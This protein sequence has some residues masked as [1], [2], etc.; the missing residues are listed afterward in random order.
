MAEITNYDEMI[1]KADELGQQ[2]S[3]GQIDDITDTL[4]N[5]RK[6]NTSVQELREA[7][8]EAEEFNGEGEE[9][10]GIAVID[11]SSGKI[12]DILDIESTSFA[13][14]TLDDI[15]ADDRI[16]AE[17]VK[18]ENAIVREES[19]RNVTKDLF[20]MNT[21]GDNSPLTVM[22]IHMITNAVDRYKKGEKFP[23][24]NAMPQI[25]KDQ[26]NAAMS[27]GE[28][29]LNM[30]SFIKQGRNYAAEEFLEYIL[31]ESIVDTEIV[32]LQH[33]MNQVMKES[34]DE[35]NKTMTTMNTTQKKYYEETLLEQAAK[36]KEHGEIEKAELLKRCSKNYIQA[37]TYENLLAMY[38]KGK[39]K[40]KPIQIDKFNRTCMEFNLKY[41]DSKT[42]ITDIS[43]VIPV[44]DRYADKKYDLIVLKEFVCAFINYTMNMKA[45]NID[46]HIFMYFFIINILSF[47]YYDEK[48]EED[49]KFHD[50]L[51]NTIN[52]FLEIICERRQ[53]KGLKGGK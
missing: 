31:K 23:Y 19:I 45:T 32:D 52:N 11:P 48:N 44:L 53:K 34:K 2:L 22:D 17:P 4:A 33:S 3:D 51:L 24:Y 25:I 12:K 43:T 47:D 14:I 27:S 13:D 1:K 6:S 7:M 15:I 28:P 42:S 49:K 9:G 16:I 36:L 21:D 29:G 20:A 38:Q 26:I 30:G 18:P 5:A 46:E 8:K 37:Y 35:L 40:V 10:E 50:N 41:K 39:L